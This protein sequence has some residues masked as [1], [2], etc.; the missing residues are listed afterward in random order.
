MN[1]DELFSTTS[2][3]IS[4][5]IQTSVACSDMLPAWIDDQKAQGYRHSFCLAIFYDGDSDNNI[6]N[7]R[8]PDTD[9]LIE[10]IYYAMDTYAARHSDIHILSRPIDD[11]HP[12]V[13]ID[14]CT[15]F[16]VRRPEQFI[17]FVTT[18][19]NLYD[20]Y[21]E[22]NTEFLGEWG[23]R[24]FYSEKLFL[25]RDE[26]FF[27]AA[28]LLTTLRYGFTRYTRNDDIIKIR[29]KD[30]ALEHFRDIFQELY[31]G[32]M[33]TLKSFPCGVT[34]RDM[35]FEIIDLSRRLY[36]ARM[37][38]GFY[39]DI[40]LRRLTHFVFDWVTAYLADWRLLDGTVSL[41]EEPPRRVR[42]AAVNKEYLAIGHQYL[43]KAK[44]WTEF[45]LDPPETTFCYQ[46]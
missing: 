9:L 2:T 32:S 21:L 27:T 15:E 11:R 42:H 38:D 16:S 25:E 40:N 8:E 45:Q 7:P 39:D 46:L 24:D 29:L 44:Y 30:T 34:A 33:D 12:A 3:D 4:K 23:E 36:R 6:F 19:C 14:F 1:T 20:E 28:I 26:P 18:I 35:A 41:D 17:N 31:M 5:A 22:K 10:Q 37:F 13:E 43:D